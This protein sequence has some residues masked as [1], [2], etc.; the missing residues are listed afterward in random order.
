MH[1]EIAKS[2]G[3]KREVKNISLIENNDRWYEPQARWPESEGWSTAPGRTPEPHPEP[4]RGWAVRLVRV[5]TS[6]RKMPATLFLLKCPHVVAGRRVYSSNI[7]R[8][9]SVA[10]LTFIHLPHNYFSSL[11]LHWLLLGTPPP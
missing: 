6:N 11:P 9:S 10:S 8:I 5:G 4:G 2:G 7:S 1:Q 3:A